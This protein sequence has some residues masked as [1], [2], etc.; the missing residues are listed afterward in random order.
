MICRLL[1]SLS[2]IFLNKIVLFDILMDTFWHYNGY[3]WHY[4]GYFLTLQWILFDTS[5]DTFWHFN[6]YFLT[7]Q[8]ILFDITM[9][10]FWHFNG[11]FLTL[12]WILLISR[13]ILW[14]LP[15]L[16]FHDI[17]WMRRKWGFLDRLWGND[18]FLI[19]W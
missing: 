5:M 6:G 14:S 15:R 11:Y 10:T 18:I 12:R 16:F 1:R 13:W 17:S 8:W 9:D 2:R 4:S 19:I 7:L 3:F